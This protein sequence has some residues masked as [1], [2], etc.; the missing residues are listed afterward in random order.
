MQWVFRINKAL[1]GRHMR[2]P[3][4]LHHHENIRFFLRSR[5]ALNNFTTPCQRR[6]V[7]LGFTNRNWMRTETIS[8]S[9][10]N[11]SYLFWLNCLFKREYK[12][13][14]SVFSGIS[15]LSR[16]LGLHIHPPNCKQREQKRAFFGRDNWWSLLP[17]LSRRGI[18]YFDLTYS[19]RGISFQFSHNI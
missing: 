16:W 6:V 17:R 3:L 4:H 5:G 14:G 8:H 19:C 15:H 10:P 13:R 11:N 2:T 7:W 18:F 12:T 9:I 1:H